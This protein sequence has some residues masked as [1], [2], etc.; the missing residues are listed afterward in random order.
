MTPKRLEADCGRCAALCCVGLAFDAGEHFAYDKP[1]GAPCKN[2]MRADR[3][4]IHDRL[5]DE[6]FSGCVR[7]NCLGAGQVVTQDLFNGRS[8]RND[9]ALL[10]PMMDALRRLMQVHEL[11]LLLRTAAALPLDDIQREHSLAL[12]AALDPAGGWTQEKLA[13]FDGSGQK[14]P[15][16]QFLR[17]L[18]DAFPDSVWSDFVKRP[19]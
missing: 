8:W 14:E 13:A 7:F 10:G 9:A 17:G 4:A 6:G 15:V 18:R 11:L 19:N 2:L 3:C 16:W 12:Q 1:A 5:E